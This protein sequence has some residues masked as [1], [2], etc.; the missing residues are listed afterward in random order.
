M[1]T[2]SVSA[3]GIHVKKAPVGAVNMLYPAQIPNSL[4]NRYS[5]CLL[6]NLGT[7]HLMLNTSLSYSSSLVSIEHY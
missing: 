6:L 1:T 5:Y 2:K 7:F 4:F 3:V